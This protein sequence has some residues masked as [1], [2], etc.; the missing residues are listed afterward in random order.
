MLVSL[1]RS[2]LRAGDDGDDPGRPRGPDRRRPS[3]CEGRHHE[4]RYRSDARGRHQ[5]RG[6]VQRKPAD[7]ELRNQLPAAEL[8]AVH[9]AR[10]IALHVNDRLQ[11]NGK[12]IVGAVET[13]T[14]TAERLVQPTSAVQYLIQPVAVQRAAAP[15]PHVRPARHA[16]ARCVERPPR[17]RL[18]LRPGQPQ[19]LHQ[20]R[21]PE[22]RQLA[23]GWRL[24]RQRL[25]QLHA[26]DHAF[27]GSDPGDQ[28]HHE[29]L[30]G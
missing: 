2:R 13:L 20:R 27:T 4:R 18:F 16:R 5:Q 15:H 28:R 24:Q 9:G 21:T 6:P 7:R 17:G 30:L 26:G 19:H 8:S 10:D 1:G 23:A 22:R 14:V 3:R 29:H 11:V 12:L 25:E